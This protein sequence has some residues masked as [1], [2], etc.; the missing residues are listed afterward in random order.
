MSHLSGLLIV[1]GV[2]VVM[3][4]AWPWRGL[5]GGLFALAFWLCLRRRPQ[6]R[7]D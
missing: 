7:D 4:E 3:I 6:D 1:L 5:A 2:L